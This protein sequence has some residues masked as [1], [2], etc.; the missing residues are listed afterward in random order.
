MMPL[1]CASP[2]GDF[3]LPEHGGPEQLQK[4]SYQRRHR[5][6]AAVGFRGS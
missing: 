4:G 1:V 2:A 6:R 5:M 3:M